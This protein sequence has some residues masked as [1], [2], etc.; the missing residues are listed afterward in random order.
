MNGNTG[1][2]TFLDTHHYMISTDHAFGDWARIQRPGTVPIVVL[3]SVW[4]S[5]ILQYTGRNED[6]YTA[7]TRFLNFSLG[8]GDN[9]Q[10]GRDE[11]KI[12]IFR[13][14]LS[15]QEPNDIKNEVLFD[16]EER[17]KKEP[18]LTDDEPD[19]FID[20]IVDESL[21]SVT[22]RREREAREDERRKADI[23]KADYQ[24]QLKSFRI[25]SEAAVNA[26][27]AETERIKN[28]F[29]DY[30]KSSAE[31][32]TQAKKN[33]AD[34]EREHIV[35]IEVEEKTPQRFR[36][37]VYITIAMLIIEIVAFALVWI[38]DQKNPNNGNVLIKFII[39]NA[40]WIIA[41]ISA[42]LDVVVIQG[43]FRGFDRDKIEQDVRKEATQKYKTS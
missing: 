2:V 42:V 27:R 8:D 9:A 3:P 20:Q 12:L 7:F 32:E 13:K 22:Q 4:Y 18:K 37:Y 19:D 5:I 21:E 24:K 14:V 43:C 38:Y 35:D 31:K 26:E 40:K 10:N 25:K 34:E 11:K 41:A 17:L 1:S 6:D 36:R 23:E 15:K 16:I 39:A 28:E 33:G 29:E 30:K